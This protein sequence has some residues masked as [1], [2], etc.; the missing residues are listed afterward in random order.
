MIKR[1]SKFGR[2]AAEALDEWKQMEGSC[3]SDNK[4][5][6]GCKRLWI[7]DKE[8][9]DISTTV[10][11]RTQAVEENVRMKNPRAA[12]VDAMRVWVGKSMNEGTQHEFF[13]GVS[14]LHE[15]EISKKAAAAE[16][17]AK[18]KA[19][20]GE[21]EELMEPEDTPR[22]TKG[23]DLDASDAEEEDEVPAMD[24]KLTKAK[25]AFLTYLGNQFRGK[26]DE[27]KTKL[28]QAQKALDLARENPVQNRSVTTDV[29]ARASYISNLD[30]RVVMAKAWLSEVPP[31]PAPTKAAMLLN[32]P[33][34]S[35][36]KERGVWGSGGGQGA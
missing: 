9:V 18:L 34:A 29:I 6:K 1:E 22:K 27:M 14:T 8:F 19:E 20:S 7:R 17:M 21:P 36:E 16:E 13:K 15:Q 25:M 4:G 3:E 26:A 30:V 35:V 28:G 31:P 33:W 12:D 32:L 24:P 2:T 10:G 5:Y 23:I 11:R